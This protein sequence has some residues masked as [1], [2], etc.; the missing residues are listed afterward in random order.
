M[1]GTPYDQ[2]RAAH[3]RHAG[4]GSM[5]W[6]ELVGWH[7]A[8]PFGHV[9]KHPEFFVMG[10]AVRKNA[11]DAQILDLTHEFAPIECDAWF[12]Y[13]FAGDMKKA[14]AALPFYLPWLCWQRIA[15]AGNDLHWVTTESIRKLTDGK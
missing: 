15:S 3:I 8:N 12:L 4:P 14:W 5:T 7:L 1:T 2:I 10:R 6:E 9:V 13:A 11:S